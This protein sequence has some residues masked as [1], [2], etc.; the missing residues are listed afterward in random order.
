MR[1]Y[2]NNDIKTREQLESEFDKYDSF[3]HGGTGIAQPRLDETA[4]KIF[5]NGDRLVYEFVHESEKE[6]MRVESIEQSKI[7][8]ET[9]YKN[10]IE[11]WKDEKIRP[12]RNQLMSLW[13]DSIRDHGELW[14]EQSDEVKSEL[15]SK[16]QELK[17]WPSLLTEYTE[18]PALPEK[19][20][21]VT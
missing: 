14:D 13:V 17:E 4:L 1:Y 6:L 3:I 9:K 18:N 20:S 5:N 7:E 2:K 15:L 19:P 16:R 12:I 21:Y 11:L 10:D 8:R